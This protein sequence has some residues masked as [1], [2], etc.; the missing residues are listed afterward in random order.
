MMDPW[1]IL[2]PERMR[3]M[4]Q[5]TSVG[6]KDGFITGAQVILLYPV[7]QMILYPAY[8]AR[9]FFMQSGLPPMVLAQIW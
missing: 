7:P 2:P 5:F 4:E 9:G 3:H 6:P 8:Q 1:V